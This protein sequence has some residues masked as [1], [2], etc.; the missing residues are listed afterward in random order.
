LTQKQAVSK[1]KVFA[2][3]EAL[4]CPKNGPGYKSQ[5]GNSRPG[6]PKYLQGGQLPP[7]LPAPMSQDLL[8]VRLV[9]TS[10]SLTR[11]PKRSLRCLLIEE[12][13]QKT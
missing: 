2:G 10:G 4:F 12:P 11:R 7:L 9:V 3:L 8:V 1:K 13:W 5:G 6:G